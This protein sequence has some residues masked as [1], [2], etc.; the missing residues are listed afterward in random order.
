M[1]K[2]APPIESIYGSAKETVV[3]ATPPIVEPLEK[4]YLEFRYNYHVD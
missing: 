1:P 2:K 3:D 4:I